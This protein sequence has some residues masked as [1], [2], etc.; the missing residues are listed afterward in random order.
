MSAASLVEPDFLAFIVDDGEAV[1]KFWTDVVALK[2]TA[3]SPLGAQVFE[4][5]PI[6][7]AIRTPPPRETAGAVAGVALWLSV[8]GDVD[9][10]REAL[11]HCG[12]DA[13]EVDDGPFSRMLSFCSPGGF[14]VTVHGVQP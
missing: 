3:H 6:P 1:A 2:R 9:E 10:Y 12:A 5:R 13:G 14:G 4:T 7:F 8:A 11:L